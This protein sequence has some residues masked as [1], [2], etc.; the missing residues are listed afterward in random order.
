MASWERP[1]PPGSGRRLVIG[2]EAAA[3][4]FLAWTT[5]RQFDLT[6]S[7][8]RLVSAALAVLWIVGACR[9]RWM[10][11]YVADGEVRIRGLLRSRTLRWSDVAE[12][13][14]HEV[15]HRVGPWSIDSGLTVLIERRDGSTVD[16][17][18]WARGVDFHR[19]PEMFRAVY[20]ELRGRHLAA[21][22]GERRFA[23]Q[24]GPQ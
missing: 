2:W 15:R 11:T 1:Y 24:P 21:G 14:L 17:E 18:L 7:G 23:V 20:Q 19:R 9:I 5:I 10:G 3:L 16:T 22:G 13:R 8:S 4:A 6:G 12:V